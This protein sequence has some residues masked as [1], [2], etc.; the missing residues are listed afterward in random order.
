M[1]EQSALHK[2]DAMLGQY[3][4]FDVSLTPLVLKV[5]LPIIQFSDIL[6]NTYH[7][8]RHNHSNYELQFFVEGNDL[9]EINNYV[10]PISNNSLLLITPG[11]YHRQKM[12]ECCA[13]K[14]CIRF[15]YMITDKTLSVH[16][17]PW[18]TEIIKI[19]TESPFLHI[20]NCD[21]LLHFFNQIREESQKK[22]L[23]YFE[24]IHVL[25]SDLFISIFRLIAD[26]FHGHQ[27]DNRDIEK[28]DLVLDLFF[29]ELYSIPTLTAEDMALHIGISVRHLNRLLKKNYNLTFRQ[30]LTATRIEVS[31]GLLKSTDLSIEDISEKTGFS[32]VE[33]FYKCFKH[34]TGMTPG[35]FKR[36]SIKN[37]FH[38]S[39]F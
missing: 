22:G 35:E 24:R 2:I 27:S 5:Y 25:L 13:L 30:K 32:S 26:K 23:F 20:E 28:E 4:K 16:E 14:Y 15:D 29:E 39:T 1:K 18:C 17:V 6:V 37:C 19:L 38:E 21:M 31:K 34:N 10:I 9:V 36:E 7:N 33:Y 11:E 8:V 3:H 12:T